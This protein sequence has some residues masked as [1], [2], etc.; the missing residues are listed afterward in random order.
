MKLASFLWKI[1][2]ILYLDQMP[3]YAASDNRLHCLVIERSIQNLNQR[4]K[5]ITIPNI[6]FV[7]KSF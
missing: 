2:N 1:T 5:Y 4:V 7:I 6:F 3:Q